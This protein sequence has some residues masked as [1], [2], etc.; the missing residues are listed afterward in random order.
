MKTTH[1]KARIDTLDREAQA[2]T[3]R[4]DHVTAQL[5]Y[6]ELNDTAQELDERTEQNRQQAVIARLAREYPGGA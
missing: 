5:R 3:A 2:A 1:L 4:G 6:V